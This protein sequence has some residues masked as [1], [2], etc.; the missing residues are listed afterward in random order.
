MAQRLRRGQP[1]PQIPLAVLVFGFVLLCPF[2]F[3]LVH[4]APAA[5]PTP[6]GGPFEL[7]R[8]SRPEAPAAPRPKG[9][10]SA[11]DEAHV[12]WKHGSV[13]ALAA[14]EI[15]AWE[16]ASGARLTDHDDGPRAPAPPK[17][18]SIAAL[19]AEAAA[20]RRREALEPPSTDEIPAFY[21]DG[22]GAPI[23]EGLDRCAAFRA[24]TRSSSGR[25]ARRPVP[26]PPPRRGA[27]APKRGVRP[28]DSNLRTADGHGG[29][30]AAT[31]AKPARE[32]RTA[33]REARRSPA[34]AAPVD[35][36]V[37]R[38]GSPLWPR[39][40]ASARFFGRRSRR[41]GSGTP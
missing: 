30:D 36:P 14:E 37:A 7:H 32:S 34:T 17:H 13:A 15:G 1:Q 26:T 24:A 11:A 33:R 39:P 12:A 10:R 22:S 25:P 4:N 20:A 38:A 18:H 5:A 41:G 19:A 23:V 35:S 3:L 21:D 27:P 9:A 40:V 6:R 2:V 16:L 29:G 8:P 28:I 31:V